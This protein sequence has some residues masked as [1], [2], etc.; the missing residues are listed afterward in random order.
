[1]L[2][3]TPAFILTTSYHSPVYRMHTRR[4]A[5][6]RFCM[7]IRCNALASAL[8]LIVPLAG[9]VSSGDQNPGLERPQVG[10]PTSARAGHAALE[11]ACVPRLALSQPRTKVWRPGMPGQSHLNPVIAREPKQ[12]LLENTVDRRPAPVP[13]RGSGLGAAAGRGV[14]AGQCPC[15]WS[16][17]QAGWQ[18]A[19]VLSLDKNGRQE[20]S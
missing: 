1:M 2:P 6:S 14:G 10:M 16:A 19:P 7:Q 18:R 13:C 20:T 8:H 4:R 15:W 3:R 11:H 9:S 17:P 12:S 5:D